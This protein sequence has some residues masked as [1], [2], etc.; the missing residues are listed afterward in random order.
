MRLPVAVLALT[1]ALSI[2]PAGAAQ[3]APEPID[4]VGLDFQ[5]INASSGKCLT[6]DLVQK[7]CTGAHRWRIRPATADGIQILEVASGTC[8]SAGN[9]GNTGNAGNAGG[10]R[11]SLSPCDTDTARIWRLRNSTGPTAEIQN[12]QSGRC[13]SVSGDAVVQ[14]TCGTPAS[15]RW[16]VRVLS[17]PIF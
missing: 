17:L 11:P 16:T 1:T 2:G 10:I 9:A 14:A 8:L 15:R 4:V 3:A 13:L 7:A 5:V 6:G 12:V